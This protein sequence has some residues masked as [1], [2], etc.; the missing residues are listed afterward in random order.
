MCGYF[1]TVANRPITN[2]MNHYV[3][4][5]TGEK[6]CYNDGDNFLNIKG[7]LWRLSTLPE[8]SK[9]EV[10]PEVKPPQQLVNSADKQYVV[11]NVAAKKPVI[12]Q[13]VQS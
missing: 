5:E 4:D 7:Q 12:L 13:P 6:A 9:P 8:G 11:N 3:C 10:K 1:E 2:I